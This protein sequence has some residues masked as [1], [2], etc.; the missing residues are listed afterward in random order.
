MKSLKPLC[1]WSGGKRDEIKTFKQFY[2]KNFKRFIEPF[3]GGGAVYFDLNFDGENVIND[4][5][6]DLINFYK[7]NVMLKNILQKYHYIWTNFMKTNS[8]RIINF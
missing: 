8:L 5:H 2:P 1:K 7:I 3:V 6:P 4:I